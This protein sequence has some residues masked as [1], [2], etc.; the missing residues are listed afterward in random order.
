MIKW[1]LFNWKPYWPVVENARILHF[2]GA[3]PADYRR[4]RK[5]G[6]THSSVYDGLLAS[7]KMDD[8]NNRCHKALKLYEEIEARIQN[9]PSARSVQLR[10]YKDGEG[11]ES[12]NALA[13][14]L[15]P[16]LLWT[17]FSIALF[18][19]WNTK[20]GLVMSCTALAIVLCLL[21]GLLGFMWSS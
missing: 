9:T 5:S 6:T 20:S 18:F 8:P 17:L 3:K 13:I 12:R 14:F 15:L 19:L 11:A 16:M 10:S 7:C 2:H 4:L 1:P 21:M